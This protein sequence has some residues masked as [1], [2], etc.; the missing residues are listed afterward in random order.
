MPAETQKKPEYHASM[1]ASEETELRRELHG[2][3]RAQARS[4]V[5]ILFAVL[6]AI[7]CLSAGVYVRRHTTFGV[8]KAQNGYLA[9]NEFALIDSETREPVQKISAADYRS[10]YTFTFCINQYESA[11]GLKPGDSWDA[12]VQ[13]YGGIHTK[14]IEI[15]HD[16]ETPI[17]EDG[18]TIDQF[19]HAYLDNGIYDRDDRFDIEFFTGT[20]GRRLYYSMDELEQA[21]QAYNDNPKFLHPLSRYGD[22]DGYVLRFVFEEGVLDFLS[23]HNVD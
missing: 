9:L 5:R 8:Q 23:S 22:F 4:S 14:T 17:I 12:F 18:I 16:G 7:L 10:A 13:Q 20:D 15:E 19:V 2:K 3:Q 1:D 21:E 6:L 11:R